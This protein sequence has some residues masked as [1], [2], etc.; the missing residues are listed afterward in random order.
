MKTQTLIALGAIT[1]F[2]G[3]ADA[4][5]VPH[6]GDGVQLKKAPDFG[7][8]LRAPAKPAPQ[9][10]GDFQF[11][12]TP[13]RGSLF[14]APVT[15][16]PGKRLVLRQRK[17]TRLQIVKSPDGN[18]L[19]VEAS[20]QSIG[21]VLQKIADVMGVRAI[22]DPQLRKETRASLFFRAKD[23]DEL[24]NL[25]SSALNIET[26]KSPEGTYFF[27]ANSA[28]S[29]PMPARPRDLRNGPFSFG[30]G[31]NAPNL[32]PDFSPLKPKPLAPQPDWEKREFNGQFYYNM[33]LPVLPLPAPDEPYSNF[34]VLPS[35][36]S[37]PMK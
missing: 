24:L 1:T 32:D 25:M 22:I 19:Q 33:P 31:E 5:N 30:P 26:A 8:L 28:S 4:Q 21:D 9:R 11:K 16:T 3:A 23:F 27:A 37:G 35:P 36:K 13:N 10:G 20:Q 7:P 29:Q 34:Y 14:G 12:L 6:D 2:A 15:I 17:G 18:T